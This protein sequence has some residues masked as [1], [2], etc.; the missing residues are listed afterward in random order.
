MIWLNVY[1]TNNDPKIIGGYF[2]EAVERLAGCPRFVRGDYGTENGRVR[3]FQT[4]IR[5]NHPDSDRSY[6][7]GASTANQRIESWWGY[8]RRHH[9]HYWIEQLKDLHDRGD[10]RGNSIEK[11]LVQFCFIA[12]IQ[13]IVDLSMNYSE[14]SICIV[15]A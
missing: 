4:F 15:S 10:F 1:N 12:L 7:D 11:S 5:R 13:V 14:I 8:L 3:D 2:L 9:M 6:I